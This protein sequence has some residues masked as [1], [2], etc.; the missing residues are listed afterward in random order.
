MG[1]GTVSH[2]EGKL[3]SR[4]AIGK[5][6][7]VTV[8]EGKR[9]GHTKL[10]TRESLDKGLDEAWLQ[11]L[12]AMEPLLLPMTDIDERI[13]EPLVSLGCE[14]GTATGFID[15]LFMSQNGYLVVVETKLWRNQ[16]A[17][18]KVVAQILDYST[19]L[20]Q[21]DYS[22]LQAEWQRQTGNSD[23]LW[24]YVHP[25]DYDDEAEWIDLVNQNLSLGRMT[26]LIVGD[27]IRSEARQLT[28]AVS[29]H[30]DFQFRLGLVELRLYRLDN[31]DVLAIPTLLVV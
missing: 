26:L 30:P 22:K 4:N 11:E 25:E 6:Y 8:N 15:N 19:Q 1:Q 29:G 31:G 27:G 14:I 28:E 9:P 21:W 7:L 5:P 17:R 10:L 24:A 16:E 18:R 20:R 2:S 13:Q 12:L 23:S 3:M